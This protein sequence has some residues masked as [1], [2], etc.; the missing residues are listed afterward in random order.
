MA[1][2]DAAS[3]PEDSNERP[4]LGATTALR[5]PVDPPTLGGSCISSFSGAPAQARLKS[6]SAHPRTPDSRRLMGKRYQ[7]QE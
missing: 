4:P 3:A 2:P 1:A 5:V 7:T 6:N